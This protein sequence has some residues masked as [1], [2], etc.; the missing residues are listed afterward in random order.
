MIVT[1][2]NPVEPVAGGRI[3]FSAPTQ[4]AS[5]SL[6]GS[7]AIIQADG[8]ASVTA[9]ADNNPGVYT[10]TASADAAAIGASFS[11]T[12]LPVDVDRGLPE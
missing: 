11:S 9:T 8:T 7:P 4:G 12:N 1:A 2:N 6:A 3:T 10:V 5:A